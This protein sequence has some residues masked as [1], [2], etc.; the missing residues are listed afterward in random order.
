[1]S[2]EEI[3]AREAVLA[4]TVLADLGARAARVFIWMFY[5]PGDLPSWQKKARNLDKCLDCKL[6]FKIIST[7]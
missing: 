1:M 2:T 5:Y 6:L 4:E 3:R 7:S